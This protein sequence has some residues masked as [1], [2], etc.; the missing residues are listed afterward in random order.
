MFEIINFLLYRSIGSSWDAHFD[1][2]ANVILD[3]NAKK[4][5][6]CPQKHLYVESLYLFI[7]F[8]KAK[9]F[10]FIFKCS[11]LRPNILSLQ[12]K[13]NYKNWIF[14]S[15]VI[16]SWSIIIIKIDVTVNN[17]LWFWAPMFQNVVNP[18][19]SNCS[20]P[21]FLNCQRLFIKD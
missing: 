9:S 12:K 13:K 10:Y 18:F 1:L 6:L 7:F 11:N 20:S 14:F 8:K 17:F 15:K 16:F 3:G 4:G 5:V 21:F 2:L 19:F